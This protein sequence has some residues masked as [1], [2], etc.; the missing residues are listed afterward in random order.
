MNKSEFRFSWFF[1]LL[2]TCLKTVV[3]HVTIFL[4]CLLAIDRYIS[5]VWNGFTSRR[6]YH[7][8]ILLIWSSSVLISVPN[9]VWLQ[10][11]EERKQCYIDWDLGKG[12]NVQDD[13]NLSL[14]A[15][16][17]DQVEDLLRQKSILDW[18]HK[19]ISQSSNYLGSR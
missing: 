11:S 4:L 3:M 14:T 2:D 6:K 19:D 12:V 16:G 18:K 7:F 10:Y 9:F 5:I 8:V 17:R 13:F 15:T 1:C